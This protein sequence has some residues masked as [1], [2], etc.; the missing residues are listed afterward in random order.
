MKALQEKAQ[1]EGA[2]PEMD[3]SHYQTKDLAMSWKKCWDN[4]F[5]G[6]SSDNWFKCCCENI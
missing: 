2:A 5:T 1:R 4:G 6:C 3:Y